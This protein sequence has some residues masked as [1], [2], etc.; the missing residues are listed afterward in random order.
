[1]SNRIATLLGH[2]AP[3]ESSISAQNTSANKKPLVVTVT[4]IRYSFFI[5][6]SSIL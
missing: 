4:G 3:V 1:M 5:L 6:F 2:L